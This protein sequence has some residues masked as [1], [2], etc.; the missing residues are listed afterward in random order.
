MHP[1]Q[2]LLL[3]WMFDQL[4]MLRVDFGQQQAA[5][6]RRADMKMHS[7]KLPRLPVQT[8]VRVRW[9]FQCAMPKKRSLPVLHLGVAGTTIISRAYSGMGSFRHPAGGF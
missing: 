1:L 4:N 6:P 9:Q 7:N 8:A 2:P 3:R 5:H